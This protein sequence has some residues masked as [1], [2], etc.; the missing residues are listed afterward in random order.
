M[1]AGNHVC[2][3]SLQHGHSCG[4][5]IQIS[6]LFCGPTPEPG[7]LAPIKV[8]ALC[9]QCRTQGHSLWSR[10]CI[11]SI[12]SDRYGREGLFSLKGSK[13]AQAFP[14]DDASYNLSAQKRSAEG[15]PVLGS[16]SRGRDTVSSLQSFG[17]PSFCSGLRP[18]ATSFEVAAAQNPPHRHSLY[19]TPTSFQN[20]QTLH[21]SSIFFLHWHIS[22][23][24]SRGRRQFFLSRSRRSATV[25]SL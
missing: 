25:K 19:S 5:S 11:G 22:S 8:H 13:L 7:I 23:R 6:H 1:H 17:I 14:F 12:G 18:T 24:R 21:L 3:R 4:L 10:S 9:L 16:R 15:F 20:T 2:G